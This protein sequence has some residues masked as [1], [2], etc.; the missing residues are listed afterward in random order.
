MKHGKSRNM[1]FY[2][3]END[4]L[5]YFKIAFVPSLTSSEPS[6]FLIAPFIVTSVWWQID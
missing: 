3:F 5:E 6:I 2:Y 4:K 1:D